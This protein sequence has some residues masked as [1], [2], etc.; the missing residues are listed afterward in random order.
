MTPPQIGKL[1][2]EPFFE[3]LIKARNEVQHV[4]IHD[5]NS[6]VDAN[7]TQL[8]TDVLNMRQ[9]IY[10]ALPRSMFD[11]KLII[12]EE[13]PFIFVLTPGNYEFIVASLAILGLGGALVPLCEFQ[14]GP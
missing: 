8:F 12:V 14:R 6:G 1:P 2:N 3:H 5:P 9:A 7:Y 13:A 4:V 10:E 11:D